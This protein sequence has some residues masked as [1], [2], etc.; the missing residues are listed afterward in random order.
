MFY[1]QH[2]HNASRSML[3]F[4][5]TALTAVSLNRDSLF[6]VLAERTANIW[7]MRRASAQ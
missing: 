1:V 6:F 2:L 3:P 7:L 5:N 4:S